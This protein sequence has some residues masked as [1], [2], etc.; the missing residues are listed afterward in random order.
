LTTSEA[1]NTHDLLAVKEKIVEID[2]AN[3]DIN[4]FLR[5]IAQFIIN[6]F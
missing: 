3:G 2:F 4:L 1:L 5:Y 6:N